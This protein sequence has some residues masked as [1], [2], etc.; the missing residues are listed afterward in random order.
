[1]KENNNA[2]RVVIIEDHD[3]DKEG[4]R[5]TV[6]HNFEVKAVFVNSQDF[7]EA[8]KTLE[9]QT[10][11]VLVDYELQK[12]G[13]LLN[14]DQII[15]RL[16][17]ENYQAKFAVITGALDAVSVLKLAKAAGASG[18]SQKAMG[19]DRYK[20][21]IYQIHE[22]NDFIIEE[23]TKDTL[24]DKMLVMLEDK[25]KEHNYDVEQKHINIIKLIMQGKSNEGI[26]HSLLFD[27]FNDKLLTHPDFDRR[28]N[29]TNFI[30]ETEKEI[31]REIKENPK[32]ARLIKLEKL[33]AALEKTHGENISIPEKFQE[34]K[35]CQYNTVNKE[36]KKHL[37]YYDKQIENHLHNYKLKIKSELDLPNTKRDTLIYGMIAY[38]LI[39]LEELKEL[40]G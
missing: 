3:F 18:F 14:G 21:F 19:I 8:Y 29:F 11:I 5:G 6:T 30:K 15:A 23:K 31:K 38:G 4:L 10:E 27:E 24:I 22:S 16:V 7:F 9:Q 33:K 32:N 40:I 17:R 36:L 35:N 39:G 12:S 13:S 37:H 2:P 26:I 34:L 20:K 1:M 25:T 28:F